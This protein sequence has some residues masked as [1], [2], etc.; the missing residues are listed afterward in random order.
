[1]MMDI[2]DRDDIIHWETKSW[3][4]DQSRVLKEIT[5]LSFCVDSLQ[6]KKELIGTIKWK[7]ELTNVRVVFP[8]QESF[9][10]DD[11]LSHDK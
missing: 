2:F 1:M 6:G 5:R 9:S 7:I 4:W 3:R 8:W 10:P 11:Q